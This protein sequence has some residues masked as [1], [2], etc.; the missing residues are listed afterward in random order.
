MKWVIGFFLVLI[1]LAMMGPFGLALALAALF[2]FV[3]A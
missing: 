3:L 1:C 2:W